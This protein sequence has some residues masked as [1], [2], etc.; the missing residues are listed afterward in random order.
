[1][2]VAERGTGMLKTLRKIILHTKDDLDR[3]N[4]DR[5]E[6]EFGPS[7]DYHIPEPDDIRRLPNPGFQEPQREYNSNPYEQSNYVRENPVPMPRPANPY[8]EPRPAPVTAPEPRQ[9]YGRTVEDQVR[10][11]LYRLDDIERRLA[12]LEGYG[13]AAPQPQPRRY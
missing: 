7:D 4:T 2:K 11:I 9:Y 8:P 6:R 10:E 5:E 12:R 1:M 3:P 13:P